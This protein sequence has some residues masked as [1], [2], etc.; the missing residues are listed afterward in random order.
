MINL[1]TQNAPLYQFH[2]AIHPLPAGWKVTGK[3]S[4]RGLEVETIGVP[5]AAEASLFPTTFESLFAEI[6]SWPR[7]FCEP[8]GSFVGVSGDD[9]PAPW[10]IDGQ[11]FDGGQGMLYI[12]LRG[13][14]T[15]ALLDRLLSALGWPAT[16]VVFQLLHEGVLLREA[17]FRRVASRS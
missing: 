12:E 8:D 5:S 11:L 6:G 16:E 13:N 14:C 17:E 3:S 15:P 7:F 10:Q 2:A 1:M 4:L 9:E